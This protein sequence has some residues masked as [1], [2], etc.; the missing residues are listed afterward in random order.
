MEAPWVFNSLFTDS[1]TMVTGSFLPDAIGTGSAMCRHLIPAVIVVL[2]RQSGFTILLPL[3]KPLNP[4]SWTHSLGSPQ[5]SGFETC[6]LSSAP[7][8]S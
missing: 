6:R 8:T 5:Q 1:A 3:I 7:G 4:G 2:Q